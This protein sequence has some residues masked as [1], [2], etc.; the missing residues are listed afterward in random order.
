LDAT[1]A[2]RAGIHIE[3]KVAEGKPAPSLLDAAE[4]ADLLVLGS[5]RHGT[6]AGIVLARSARNACGMRPAHS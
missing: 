6:L 5:S 1:G 3:R 4:G 2:G